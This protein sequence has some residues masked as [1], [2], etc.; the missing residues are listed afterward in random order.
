MRVDNSPH[1]L[2]RLMFRSEK[3]GILQGLKPADVVIDVSD[4]DYSCQNKEY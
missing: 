4:I 3:D 1:E 2:F